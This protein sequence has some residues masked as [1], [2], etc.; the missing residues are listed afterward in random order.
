MKAPKIT[1]NFWPV[2][3]TALT[4][5]RILGGTCSQYSPLGYASVCRRFA[6]SFLDSLIVFLSVFGKCSNEMAA[7][8]LVKTYCLPTLKY[9]SINQSINIFR[10]A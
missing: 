9:G 1:Y 5:I 6:E 4:N 3:Q 7:V 2:F 8:H 10:V